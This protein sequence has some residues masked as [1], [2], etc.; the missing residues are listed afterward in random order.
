MT[1]LGARQVQE[2]LPAG[3]AGDAALALAR[4]VCALQVAHHQLVASQ[5]AAAKRSDAALTAKA[6]LQQAL[7]VSS[8]PALHISACLPWFLVYTAVQ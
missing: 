3:E 6:L 4:Q 1:G 8:H 2:Q 5:A 7:Q